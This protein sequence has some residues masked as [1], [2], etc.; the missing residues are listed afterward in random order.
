MILGFAR[1]T[2]VTGL[3]IFASFASASTVE[4]TLNGVDFNV[5]G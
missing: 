2:A 1:A 3:L 4:W 5:V